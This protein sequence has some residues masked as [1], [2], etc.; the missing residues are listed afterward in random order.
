MCAIRD[1]G[2]RHFQSGPSRKR[3]VVGKTSPNQFAPLI[4]RVFGSWALERAEGPFETSDS[5]PSRQRSAA[6]WS[7]ERFSDA[8]QLVGDM[9]SHDWSANR[10]SATG[11]P[12]LGSE[13]LAAL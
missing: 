13:S 2:S 3:V 7:A 5:D 12:F 6:C 11:F 9:E 4:V 1:S 10:S 8:S